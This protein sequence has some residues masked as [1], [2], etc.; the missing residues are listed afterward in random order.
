MKPGK[1]MLAVIV[2]MLAAFILLAVFGMGDEVQGCQV[3]AAGVTALIV[4]LH[5]VRVVFFTFVA[6]ILTIIGY[7]INDTIVVC[8]RIRENRRDCRNMGI[9]ELN[10]RSV[11]QVLAR[12]GNTSLTTGICVLTILTRCF[13]IFQITSIWEF[14]L[15]M[16]FG[17]ISGCYS[18][19][20]IASILWAVWE[21]KKEDKNGI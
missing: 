8:D 1:K 2:V 10:D 4:L 9:I 7:S 16:F 15:P 3:W 14:A 5:D 19:V 6:V 12:S 17:L 11:S 20:C 13:L 21:K 18:S